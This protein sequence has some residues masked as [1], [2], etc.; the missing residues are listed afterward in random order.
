MRIILLL[1]ASLLNISYA[2]QKYDPEHLERFEK[3]NECIRCNLSRA[4]ISAKD[5]HGAILRETVLN[6]ARL[7]DFHKSDFT[8]A[9]LIEA[10]TVVGRRADLKYST[11]NNANLRNSSLFSA[12]LDGSDFIKADLSNTDFYYA[13]LTGADFTGADTTN[14]NFERSDLSRAIITSEQ[15]A[16]A[17]SVCD[18]ILPDGSRGSCTWR[19]IQGYYDPE[20]L[21]HFKETNECINCDLSKVA[22]LEA[23]N[24]SGAVLRGSILN[25][26]LLG[27]FRA[28]DFTNAS[29]IEVRQLRKDFFRSN[30]TNVNFLNARL[31]EAT[32]TNT[33]FSGAKLTNADFSGVDFTGSNVTQEQLSQAKSICNAVLPDGTLGPCD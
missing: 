20:D 5:G 12:D 30:F 28:T 11:F 22:Y 21:A 6:R 24:G 27:N 7:G 8:G 14:S 33:D 25:R 9:F 32:L 26:S 13:T 3:T 23:Q 10:R 15:L 2:N 29:L 18:A 1:V 17:R 4:D 16:Q 31:K 19:E